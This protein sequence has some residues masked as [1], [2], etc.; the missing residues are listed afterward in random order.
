MTEYVLIFTTHATESLGS[1]SVIRKLFIGD[2]IF[3]SRT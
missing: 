2:K 1:V 3:I